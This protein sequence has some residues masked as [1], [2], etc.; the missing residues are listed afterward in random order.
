M[1]VGGNVLGDIQGQGGFSHGWAGGQ[2]N[3]IAPL[4]SAE[5]IIQLGKRGGQSG[6]AGAV[7]LLY[8]F[9]GLMEQ[10]LQSNRLAGNFHSGYVKDELFSVL[11]QFFRIFLPLVSARDNL[12]RSRYEHP[13]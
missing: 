6:D 4:Q 7:I 2:D 3:H 9:K 12:R 8:L 13:Q 5:H 11:E 1:A 10:F